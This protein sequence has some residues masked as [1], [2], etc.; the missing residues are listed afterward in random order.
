MTEKMRKTVVEMFNNFQKQ[1]E[2]FQTENFS[3]ELFDHSETEF[4]LEE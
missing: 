3:N 1:I 2:K 4:E